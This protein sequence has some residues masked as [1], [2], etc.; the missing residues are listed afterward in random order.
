MIKVHICKESSGASTRTGGEGVGVGAGVGK[1]MKIAPEGKALTL[2]LMEL[3]GSRGMLPCHVQLVAAV[4]SA[5][6][7][8]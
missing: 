1:A 5:E 2:W 7:T 4:A 3:H 6:N 8:S